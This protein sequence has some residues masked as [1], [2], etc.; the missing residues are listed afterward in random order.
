[1][2][3]NLSCMFSDILKFSSYSGNHKSTI[4][5]KGQFQYNMTMGETFYHNMPWHKHRTKKIVQ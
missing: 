5:F 2:T 3:H 4:K 1:M